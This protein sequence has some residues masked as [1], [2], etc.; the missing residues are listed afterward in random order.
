MINNDTFERRV[1]DV[2][3]VGSRETWHVC[4]VMSVAHPMHVHGVHFQVRAKRS[5]DSRDLMRQLMNGTRT[6]RV[7]YTA[8]LNLTTLE[9]ANQP[10]EM[11][12]VE[13]NSC[14]ELHVIVGNFEGEFVWH[15]H[16]LEHEDR[17]MMRKLTI[18]KRVVGGGWQVWNNS[19]VM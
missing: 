15:C 7:R 16:M 2:L 19:L 14:S 10:R 13:A 11:V 5:I 12:V 8:R 18:A 17:A 9:H 6:P 3:K 4:N 1:T